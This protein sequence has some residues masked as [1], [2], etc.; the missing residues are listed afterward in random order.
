MRCS[1]RVLLVVLCGIHYGVN[2][3]CVIRH[4]FS[5]MY[6]SSSISFAASSNSCSFVNTMYAV[7][8]AFL[9]MCAQSRSSSTSCFLF[10]E[11]IVCS[12]SIVL[13]NFFP[14]V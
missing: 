3:L 12:L 9:M 5:V 2:V 4:G 8:L 7:G 14:I 1:L 6:V 10:S 13:T 11:V